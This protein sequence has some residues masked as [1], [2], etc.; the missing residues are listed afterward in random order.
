MDKD[1]ALEQD[2]GDK[3]F[4]T[5]KARCPLFPMCGGCQYQHM[6]YG[7]QLALKAQRME[8]LFS[9]LDTHL[10]PISPPIPSPRIYF[11]RSKLTPHYRRIRGAGDEPI[12]FLSPD[13]ST[14]V[15]IPFCPIALEEINGALPEIRARIRSKTTKRG[16]TALLRSGDGTVTDSPREMIRETVS[17][18]TFHFI[19]GE[20]FQNNS[21]ILPDLIGC[22]RS[23][24][25]ADG[26]DHLV[27]AYCGVGLFAISLA[28]H[29]KE[30]AAV[31]ICRESVRLA[32]LNGSVNGV[33]SATFFA[34]AAESLF[35]SV[36]FPPERTAVLLDPPRSGCSRSFCDQLLKFGARRIVYVSCGPES[37]VRDLCSIL[38]PYK[39]LQIQPV[40]M[41]PQTR[42]V[43]NIVLLERT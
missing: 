25:A 6:A 31:E 3:T 13:G 11:Y 35:A 30:I 38:G 37:Q 1:A 8:E 27:D 2:A 24:A 41:F 14:L 19:A 17:G 39:I 29:F 18:K 7:D 40:D 20:F 33:R 12:G 34:G 32:K 42:H 10:P 15:D 21:S 22:V 4:A 23:M 43:E 9:T 36:Q 28:E 26:I 5:A 16:G